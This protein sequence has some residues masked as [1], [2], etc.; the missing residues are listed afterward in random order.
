MFCGQCGE[1]LSDDLRFCESS[2]FSYT[3]TTDEL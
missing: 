3:V 2:H 1:N